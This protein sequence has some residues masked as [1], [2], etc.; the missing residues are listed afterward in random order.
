[1]TTTTAAASSDRYVA[2]EIVYLAPGHAGLH[3]RRGERGVPWI[4]Q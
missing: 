1:M 3:H 2:S 4:H